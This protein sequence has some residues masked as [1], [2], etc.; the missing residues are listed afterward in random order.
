[1]RVIFAEWP[2]N[3]FFNLAFEEA[4]MRINKG[5]ALRL[6]RNDRAVIIGRHQCAALEVNSYALE[7]HGVKL[8]RRFTGGGAVYHDLGN[9][10]YSIVA[11]KEYATNVLDLFKLVGKTISSALESLGIEGVYYRPLNDIEVKGLK[12]SGLAGLTLSDRV[13]VHGALLVGSDLSILGK[14]LKISREKLSDKKF[15]ES[16]RKRVTTVEEEL[17]RKVNLKEIYKAIVDSLSDTLKLT[18]EESEP[19]EEEIGEALNLYKGK[20]SRL[21]WNLRYMNFIRDMLEEREVEILMKVATP[22]NEQ[23]KIIGGLLR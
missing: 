16:R 21:S 6:W 18:P 14:V 19:N 11:G 5:P 7:E 12:I 23:E 17:G 8:V 4:F 10:N 3:P 13:F 9:I 2:E 15:T 22:D 20:Y 1:M